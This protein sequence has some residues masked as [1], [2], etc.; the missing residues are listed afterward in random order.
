MDQGGP[1]EAW[2]CSLCKYKIW[3]V[4]GG[5]VQHHPDLREYSENETSSVL[6]MGYWENRDTDYSVGLCSCDVGCMYE[7]AI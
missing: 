7:R 2:V 3:N 6:G 4:G 5:W 1:S